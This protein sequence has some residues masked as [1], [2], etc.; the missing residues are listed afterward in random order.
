M[1]NDAVTNFPD[2]LEPVSGPAQIP[3]PPDWRKTRIHTTPTGAATDLFGENYFRTAGYHDTPFGRGVTSFRARSS[4]A[5]TVIRGLEKV[6]SRQRTSRSH[7]EPARKGRSFVFDASV[8]KYLPDP[9]ETVSDAL[10]RLEK[11]LGSKQ[12]SPASH[13]WWIMLK[14]YA[15]KFP[16]GARVADLDKSVTSLALSHLVAGR[17]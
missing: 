5:D 16:A 11:Q 10:E 14:R 12:K 13:S 4:D 17:I 9:R 8:A 2:G 1:K 15:S 3:S 6:A 7:K